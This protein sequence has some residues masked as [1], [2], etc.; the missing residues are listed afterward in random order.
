MTLTLEE[1]QLQN[2]RLRYL[3]QID[4]GMIE[5]KLRTLENKMR[6]LNCF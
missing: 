1:E 6:Q 4:E 5:V 3:K 2:E